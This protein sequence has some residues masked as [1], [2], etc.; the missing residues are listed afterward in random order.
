MSRLGILFG[1]VLA[2]SACFC[3]SCGSNSGS[4][5]SKA[6]AQGASAL[7]PTVEVVKVVSRK[8]AITV[9]LPGELQP[10][11]AVAVFPKVTSFVDWIGVDRGSV[12]KTGQLMVRLVAPEIVAQ[13]GESQSKLQEAVAQR[14]ESEAKLASEQST[15]ERLKTASATPGVVA[16]NDLEVAQKAVEGNR[17]RLN[18]AEESEKAAK[19]ALQSITEVQGYLQVHA[20]FDGVV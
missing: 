9:R 7:A 19:A 15:Y 3:S 1:V 12:V 14:A 5:A 2:G 8:L 6:N 13:G 11:E 17:A 18:A 20:P 10:Y 4:S 16:G